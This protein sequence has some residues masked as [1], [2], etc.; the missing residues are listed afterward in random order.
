MRRVAHALLGLVVLLAGCTAAVK[1][2]ARPVRPPAARAIVAA[3]T[4]RE[5]ATPGLRLSMSVKIS[6]SGHD[7]LLPAPAYLAVD[8][9][10]GVRLQVLSPFG[11]TVL[12]LAIRG[13]RYTVTMPLTHEIRDGTIDL[14][15]LSDP[16][17]PVGDRMIVAL[18]LMFR[19]KV[20]ADACRDG[21][22]GAIICAIGSGVVARIA[23]DDGLRPVR[24]VY[25]DAAARPLLTA[26]FGDYRGED[27]QAQ[28]GSLLIA[29]PSSGA[30]M[31]IQ[32]KR[33]RT[34]IA[35]T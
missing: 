26:T 28:P 33:V 23:V 9:A 16:S 2:G 35:P 31:T 25:L 29:D 18:A 4:A 7:P 8:D 21:G 6:G 14:R 1:A 22:P 12:D 15:T 19:P 5:A 17:V 24:E 30:R 34:A 13:E 3:L 20:R 32:V 27:A 11:M 10:G